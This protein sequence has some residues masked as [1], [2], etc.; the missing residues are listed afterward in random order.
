MPHPSLGNIPLH[1]KYRSDV[2]LVLTI[3]YAFVFFGGF[4]RRWGP[5]E[6]SILLPAYAAGYFLVFYTGGLW[7]GHR[8]LRVVTEPIAAPLPDITMHVVKSEPVW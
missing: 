7:I 5:R 4:A 8:A 3:V 1:L 6:V 2:I